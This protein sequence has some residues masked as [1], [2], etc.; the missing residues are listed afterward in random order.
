MA[1][2]NRGARDGH[3]KQLLSADF[4]PLRRQ[5]FSAQGRDGFASHSHH[6]SPGLRDFARIGLVHSWFPC[7]SER[8]E[9]ALQK[10]ER[11]RDSSSPRKIRG[12]QSA[13]YAPENDKFCFGAVA[14]SPNGSAAFYLL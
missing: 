1:K 9:E 13:R 3:T 14:F 12:T 8:S 5:R 6:A 7:H 10:K 11:K 2:G 4:R